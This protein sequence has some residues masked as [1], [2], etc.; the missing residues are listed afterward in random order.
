MAVSNGRWRTVGPNR[1]GSTTDLVP[2]VQEVGFTIYVNAAA[3][4]PSGPNMVF[5][6]PSGA[7]LLI[8]SFLLLL[9]LR[10]ETNNEILRDEDTGLPIYGDAGPPGYGYYVGSDPIVGTYAAYIFDV[11]DLDE[12]GQWSVVLGSTS[13]VFNVTA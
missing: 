6:K 9:P 3:V 2:Q 8:P 10:N 7:I 11:A 12:T 4:F 13:A 1:T 5:T